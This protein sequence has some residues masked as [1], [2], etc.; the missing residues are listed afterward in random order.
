MEVRV[1]LLAD[2]IHHWLRAVVGERL[3]EP[4]VDH[5]H[6]LHELVVLVLRI[7][8]RE[9]Q[10]VNGRQ[11]VLQ[12]VRLGVAV[13]VFTVACRPLLVVVEVRKRNR[14]KRLPVRILR[15]FRLGWFRLLSRL[16][17]FSGLFSFIRLLL[18]SRRLFGRHGLLRRFR[19]RHRRFLALLFLFCLLLEHCRLFLIYTLPAIQPI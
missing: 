18:L 2:E 5:L 13:H 8:K 19:F 16:L 10:V 11:D 3:E 7:G 12:N 14:V 6:A 17:G 15:L 9:P 1:Q 4:V